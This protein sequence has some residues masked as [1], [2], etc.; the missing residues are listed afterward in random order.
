MCVCVCVFVCVCVCV[1]CV[2]GETDPT[3][4]GVGLWI[5]GCGLLSWEKL[6]KRQ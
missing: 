5:V 4:A 3:E 6:K 2:N 1:V